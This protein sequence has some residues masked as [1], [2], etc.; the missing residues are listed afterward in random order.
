MLAV[1]IDLLAARYHA[2]PWGRAANEGA[3]E[4]PPSPWR[5]GRALVSAWWRT[6]PDERLKEAEVD[7][8]LSALAAPPRFL[9]P[10]AI[11]AHTRHF[12]PKADDKRTL[13]LDPFI[14]TDGSSPTLV[15][16]DIELAAE[17]RI[18]LGG[19]LERIGYLGRAEAPCIARLA[20][21]AP[22]A[23]VE[24]VPLAGATNPDAV[25]IVRVLCLA[26]GATVA[27]LSA[28]TA[29]RRKQRLVAPPAGRFLSYV[30]PPDALEAPRRR[31]STTAR[32]Q[33]LGLRFAIEGASLPPVTE[34][35][36]LAERYRAAV[37][38]R[39]DRKPAEVVARLRGRHPSTGEI[40]LGHSHAHYLPTDEDGDR[41]LDH[42]TV[43]CPAGIRTDEL[44]ALA[45]TTLR[46]WAFEHPLR[47]IL[48]DELGPE[49]EGPGPLGT[50][51]RWRSHTPF[52]PVRHPKRRRGA[53]VDG[54]VHQVLLELERRGLPRPLRVEAIAGRPKTW[55]EFR[56][57]RDRREPRLGTPALGFEIE[58]AQ[59][60]RGP[61]ALGRHSHFGMGL[62]LPAE[63]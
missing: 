17:Q 57:E 58:F 13:V 31:R 20:D 2:T 5:L 63:R 1:A 9:L 62:F 34:A 56:R 6:P 50:A 51:R 4:W 33:V 27:A 30:Q 28:S 32:R 21:A 60:V 48:T 11:S 29:E 39:A 7:D 43:W 10:R 23:A 61:V 45:L 18:D 12:M 15:W 53:T 55:G 49:R 40:L 59:S 16:D 37:L 46:S 47:L 3:A 42:L 54:Y 19:L 22:S 8:L 26:D 41:R 14:R 24:V 25:E 36:R 38:K 35:L 44:D 52:L